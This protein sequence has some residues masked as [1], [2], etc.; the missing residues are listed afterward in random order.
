MQ[1][2]Q[3]LTCLGY[4]GLVLAWFQEKPWRGE[5]SLDEDQEEE[6][7]RDVRIVRV[8]RCWLMKVGKAQKRHL[9]KWDSQMA[10]SCKIHNI[11][12]I[13]YFN[14]TYQLLGGGGVIA[15]SFLCTISL[16]AA[17]Q[18]KFLTL[19]RRTKIHVHKSIS[20]QKIENISGML[21]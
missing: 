2:F 10:L 3:I 19:L 9:R 13:T 11:Y 8:R 14:L 5:A 1:F 12:L 15:T 21:F 7:D 6:I 16:C 20:A 18:R 17:L 4:E